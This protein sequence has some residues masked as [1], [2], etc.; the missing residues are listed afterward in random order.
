VCCRGGSLRQSWRTKMRSAP[1]GFQRWPLVW[2]RCP[3]C[4]HHTYASIAQIRLPLA[5]R[6]LFRFWCERCG[7]LS[8]LKGPLWLPAVLALCAI[9]LSL[10]ALVAS[11]E[12]L[13]QYSDV[14]VYAAFVVF[15]IGWAV[16][17]RLGNRY[18]RENVAP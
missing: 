7:S 17:N 18:A 14:A 8:I 1:A 16:L 15:L 2:F 13:P 9:G 11:L 5:K 6:T 10:L 12:L 3:S 4:S